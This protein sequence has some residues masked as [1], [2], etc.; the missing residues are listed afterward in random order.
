MVRTLEDTALTS[1]A[2]ARVD[3]EISGPELVYTVERGVLFE[4]LK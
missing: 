4:M 1:E 2:V 3:L